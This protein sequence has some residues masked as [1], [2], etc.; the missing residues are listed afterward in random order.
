MRFS[1]GVAQGIQNLDEHW[2]GG[3]M[4]ARLRGDAIPVY[5]RIALMAQVIDV[6]HAGNGI[7]AA[8]RE[9]AHRSGSWFDPDLVAAFQR[10]ADREAFWAT[11]RS[12]DLQQAIFA[13][14]PGAVQPERSTR[15][16][17]TISRPPSPR[18]STPR[19][20]TPAVTAS[21]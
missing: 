15:I 6:F 14:E 8:R 9:I 12:D 17:S 13:L 21:G 19:A 7:A 11:L 20:P 16:I 10:V 4:P 18:W 1:E 5:A 2:D 3:G